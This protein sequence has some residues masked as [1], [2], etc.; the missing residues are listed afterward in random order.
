MADAVATTVAKSVLADLE[1]ASLSQTITP[2]RS[3]ADWEE[4]LETAATEES[5]LLVDVVANTTDQTL[6]AA[7]RGSEPKIQYIVVVDVAVRCRFGQ[8]KQNSETGRVKIEE[9]DSLVLLVQEIHEL[10]H[11]KRTAN[12][13]GIVWHEPAKVLV[14]PDREHLRKMKQFTGIVR[15]SFE[16]FRAQG[17][18]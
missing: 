8:D 17:S 4:P 14:N 16:A 2:E 15:L 5:R 13:D 10:F 1:A 11:L 12:A 7:T 18:A 9:V 6:V 3:Y